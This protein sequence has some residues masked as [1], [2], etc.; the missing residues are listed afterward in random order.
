MNFPLYNTLK[1][2]VPKKDLTVSQKKSLVARIK[3]LDQEGYDLIFA[4]IKCHYTENKHGENLSLP[5]SAELEKDNISFDLNKLPNEL[6]QILFK[7]VDIHS[8]KLEE[9]KEFQSSHQE[10]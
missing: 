5:Y 9:D 1:T 3:D 10:L 4:L 2:N 6:K 7:F 8:K